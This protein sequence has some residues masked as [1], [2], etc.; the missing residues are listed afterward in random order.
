MSD[1]I[2][3]YLAKH[4]SGEPGENAYAAS[5]LAQLAAERDTL[6]T[7]ARYLESNMGNG[8]ICTMAMIREWQ[9]EHGVADIMAADREG[10][11]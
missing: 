1:T 10:T 6:L 3:D 4:P 7:Y 8:E 9:A 2:R 5:A 11:A